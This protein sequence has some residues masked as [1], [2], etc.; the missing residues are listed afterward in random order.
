VAR[1]MHIQHF[2]LVIQLK[3]FSFHLRYV[4]EVLIPTWHSHFLPF[5][6]NCRE[7]DGIKLESDI[8][9]RSISSLPAPLPSRA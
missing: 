8:I 4:D 5:P 7:I 2:T 1:L 6:S 3:I 9:G